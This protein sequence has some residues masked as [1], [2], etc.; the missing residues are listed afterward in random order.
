ML[1]EAG[2]KFFKL[3]VSHSDIHLDGLNSFRRK[4]LLFLDRYRTLEVRELT[5]SFIGG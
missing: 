2:L 5:H 4:M 1:D 3:G